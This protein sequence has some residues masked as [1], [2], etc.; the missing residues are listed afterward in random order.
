MIKIEV[1]RRD[2]ASVVEAPARVPE[3][4]PGGDVAEP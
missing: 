1:S 4:M 3:G 2:V